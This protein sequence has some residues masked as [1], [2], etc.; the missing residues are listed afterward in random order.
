MADDDLAGADRGADGVLT[1]TVAVPTFRRNAHLVELVPALLDQLDETESALPGTSAEVLVVDN[2]PA[3]GAACAME[4][5]GRSDRVRY[6]HEPVPGLS[7][8]RNRALSASADRRLLAFIDDDGRPSQ[9]WLRE[10]VEAQVRS[11][12]AGVA[13]RVLEEYEREPDAWIVAGRFFRRRSMPSGTEVEAAPAGNLLLDLDALRRLGLRF[14]P[15]FGTSGGEDTLLTRQLT[16]S[17]ARI[18]WCDEARIVDKVAADRLDRRWVLRRSWSH[19]NTGALV[20]QV[21][22]PGI[23]TR[24]RCAAGG[25]A[26]VVGGLL[27]S[28]AGTVLRSPEHQARGLR[29]AAR[30][31]GMVAGAFGAVYQEYAR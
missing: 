25:A 13:G 15:R 19:G 31:A 14:D 11:G 30:G 26:R 6:V 17:G 16:A 3:G 10:L 27:R 1:V 9:G 2:D 21:L 23:G 18:V 22:A 8:A 20:E 5:V 4:E 12:A 29:A 24:I 28:A 7:A